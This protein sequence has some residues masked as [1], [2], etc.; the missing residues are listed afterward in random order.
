MLYHVISEEDAN[1]QYDEYL[2]DMTPPVKIGTLTFYASDIVKSCD[3]I[4]Y[5]IM[6]GEYYDFLADDGIYVKGYTDDEM[7]EEDN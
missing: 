5:D 1:T 7:P 2:D 6:L 4:A 3:P